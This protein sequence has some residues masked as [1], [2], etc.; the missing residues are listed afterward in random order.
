MT[1][2]WSYPDAEL[3]L[4]VEQAR[5]DRELWLQTRRQGIGGSD[6]AALF[7]EGRWEDSTEYGLWLDKT[8][9]IPD[10]EQSDAMK[11]GNILEDSVARDYAERSGL[12]LRRVG[13]LRSKKHPR[14]FANCDRLT[15]D[16]AGIEVKTGNFFIGKKLQALPPG[17][18]PRSWYWQGLTCIAVTGR[19]HWYFAGL[20]GGQ[21]EWSAVLDRSHCKDDIERIFATAPAWY[22]KHVIGDEPPELGAPE[23][24]SEIE[25]GSKVEA[26]LPMIAWADQLEWRDLRKQAKQIEERID[27][28][29]AS[30]KTELG[31][32]NILTVRGVP[33]VRMQS[34]LGN[35][36]FQKAQFVADHPGIT[37]D[38]YYKRNKASRFPVLIGEDPTE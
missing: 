6:M 15:D 32:S 38:D 9:R 8:A 26:T 27:Q 20:F 3:V 28:I 29:K 21:I 16:G 5:T 18:I 7:G 4:T 33:L 30:F 2:N 23:E 14:V 10:L 12:K 36:T 17:E 13:L 22:E 24:L 1:A 31:N 34:R 37:V 19:S 35:N 25:Q 11:W